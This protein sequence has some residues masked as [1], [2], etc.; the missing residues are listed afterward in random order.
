M[1]AEAWVD[2]DVVA[3]IEER[4]LVVQLDVKA[5]PAVYASLGL[6]VLPSMLYFSPGRPRPYTSPLTSRDMTRARKRES[7]MQ[8]CKNVMSRDTLSSTWGRS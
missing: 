7:D 4:A 3:W 8:C 5:R 6:P 1:D 2:A